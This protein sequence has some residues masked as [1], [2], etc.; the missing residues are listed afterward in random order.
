[1]TITPLQHMFIATSLVTVKMIFTNMGLGN[2]RIKANTRAPEDATMVGGTQ[3]WGE[4]QQKRDDSVEFAILKRWERIINND[5]E[6]IPMQVMLFWA[7]YFVLVEA[8]AST[9]IAIYSFWAFVT[10]RI[11]FSIFYT[12]QVQPFR[13]I[14]FATGLLSVFVALGNAARTI[15]F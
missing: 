13:T 8:N 11:L 4:S 7:I 10:S 2:A 12:F 9:D 5:V 1:M 15:F 6:N 3:D 14:A